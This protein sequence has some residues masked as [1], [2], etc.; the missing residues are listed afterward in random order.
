MRE[1]IISLGR[2]NVILIITFLSI[3]T[4]VMMYIII[5]QV[6][7]E[8]V[9]PSG[10]ITSVIVP[11]IIAPLVSWYLIRIFFKLHYLEVETRALATY[12]SL[13]Q[14]MSRQAFLT[15]ARTLYQLTKREQSSLC[16]VY[17]DVDNFK[18][19]NDCH[20]HGCGDQ[21]LKELGQLINRHK[22]ES[23]L[24]G[25]IGGEEFALVLNE[26]NVFGAK[27]FLE[28]LQE[29]VRAHVVVYDNKT[30]KFTVS[31]GFTIYSKKQ[32]S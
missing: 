10:V 24:A 25:R 22:R 14:L 15:N 17:I 3:A 2:L 9:M 8:R 29:V 27:E 31:M 1:Q 18:Q 19:I 26:T 7:Q 6:M 32:S 28:H 23:D 20:G 5:A 11:S 13:S 16:I 4:S 12:D 30:V 21:V